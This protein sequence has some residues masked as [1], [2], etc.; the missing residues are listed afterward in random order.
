MIV[1][2][3]DIIMYKNG[4]PLRRLTDNPIKMKKKALIIFSLAATGFILF[5]IIGCTGPRKGRYDRCPTFQGAHPLKS[6]LARQNG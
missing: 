3:S 1:R 5:G 2:H 6:Q 4:Q